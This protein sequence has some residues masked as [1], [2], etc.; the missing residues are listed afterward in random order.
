M[1]EMRLL[2]QY[3]HEKEV[4]D[5]TQ[6][7]INDY[8]IYIKKVHGVGYAKCRSVAHACSFFYKKVIQKPFL[9]PT[10]LYPRKEFKLPNVMTTEDSAQLFRTNHPMIARVVLS[11][12][13]GCGLRISEVQNLKIVDIESS[14]NRIKICQAKGN[15]DR[16]VLLPQ[17]VL[18]TLRS[19]YKD[20][21]PRP[22]VYLLESIQTGKKYHCRSLQLMINEAMKRA[23]LD[24]K[25]YTA[26]TLRH[27]FATHM[28]DQGA[29][30][31]AIK[32]LLGHSKL[33][34]TMIYL[35]LQVSTRSA[36]V[37]P[38]DKIGCLV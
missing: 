34:T 2:F 27:S 32:E 17:Y 9:L 19:Y 37:S 14:Q 22:Q 33:E 31:V 11:L 3:Y 36:M 1:S 12:L 16:M 28:L 5:I 7:D 15:K 8:I 26:H 23:G 18:E 13:Y 30:L 29:S 6:S 38:I 10:T 21:H 20:A 35:H 4:E 24:S 25:G